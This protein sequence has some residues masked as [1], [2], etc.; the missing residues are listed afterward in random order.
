MG[1]LRIKFTTGGTLDPKTDKF[2]YQ[3]P[4]LPVPILSGCNMRLRVAHTKTVAPMW[5]PWPYQHAF[6]KLTSV[7]ISTVFDDG[8]HVLV[9]GIPE[10]ENIPVHVF[11]NWPDSDERIIRLAFMDT[12]TKRVV[13]G[14]WVSVP[15]TEGG[16]QVRIVSDPE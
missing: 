12:V 8:R 3:D 9:L 4:T 13:Y 14:D 16:V 11:L 6:I 1:Q 2:P 5:Q 7:V 15:H 10:L